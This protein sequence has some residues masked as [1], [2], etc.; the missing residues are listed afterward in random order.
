MAAERAVAMP[1]VRT[2]GTRATVVAVRTIMVGEQTLA[3]AAVIMVVAVRTLML[4]I[5]RLANCTCEDNVLISAT[6]A[7]ACIERGALCLNTEN[8]GLPVT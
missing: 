7:V 1:L 6:S 4:I 8:V 2:P 5:Y 3:A